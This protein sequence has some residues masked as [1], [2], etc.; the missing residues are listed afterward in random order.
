MI[1]LPVL[2]RR[3]RNGV[4]SFCNRSVVSWSWSRSIGVAKSRV[5]EAIEPNSPGLRN[6]MID[7]N[8]ASRFSTGVPVRATRRAASSW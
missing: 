4:S 6:C 2:S 7:H 8:S 1:A 3:S 5:N